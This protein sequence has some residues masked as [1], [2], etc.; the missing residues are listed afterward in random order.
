[1][2]WNTFHQIPSSH[3]IDVRDRVVGIRANIPGYPTKLCKSSSSTL[4][5]FYVFCASNA[6]GWLFE[7]RLEWCMCTADVVGESLAAVGCNCVALG[8]VLTGYHWFVFRV[9]S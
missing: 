6:R 8:T 5:A 9:C 7:S 1:V 4:R 3:I 2:D